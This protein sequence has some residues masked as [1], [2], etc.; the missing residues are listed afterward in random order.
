MLDQERLEGLQQDCS[1]C[2]RSNWDGS[3]TVE[4]D[5]N[6]CLLFTLLDEEGE[7]SAKMEARPHGET[8]LGVE[9]WKF[10]LEGQDYEPGTEPVGTLVPR[11]ICG[12]L[13]L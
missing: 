4:Q 1:N 7:E 13:G 5:E 3:V 2:A 6:G 10:L 11:M 9:L 8:M 12:M